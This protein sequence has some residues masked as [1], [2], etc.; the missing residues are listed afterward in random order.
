MGFRV[1]EF[2]DNEGWNSGRGWVAAANLSFNAIS[3]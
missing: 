1:T 2:F 3:F